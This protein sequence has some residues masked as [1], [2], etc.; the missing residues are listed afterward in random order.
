MRSSR[1]LGHLGCARPSRPTVYLL[2]G[3]AS[4]AFASW[5][6]CLQSVLM[7]HP[8]FTTRFAVQRMPSN[9]LKQGWKTCAKR[10]FNSVSFTRLLRGI[11]NTYYGWRSS[12]PK[13]E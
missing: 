3:V 2:D 6:T 9:N 11:G 8:K 7:D 10:E 5:W 4:I 13:T 12:P 1:T